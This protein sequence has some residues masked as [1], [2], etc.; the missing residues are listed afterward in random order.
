MCKISYYQFI[1]QFIFVTILVF[2]GLWI[3]ENIISLPSKNDL[4]FIEKLLL[5]TVAMHVWPLAVE[6]KVLKIK[7]GKILAIKLGCLD[8]DFCSISNVEIELEKTFLRGKVYYFII[9][10]NRTISIDERMYSSREFKIIEKY[11]HKHNKITETK[12]SFLERI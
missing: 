12:K 1:Y 9:S 2:F 4:T 10:E 3:F 6:Y 8:N 5:I 11:I 7:N